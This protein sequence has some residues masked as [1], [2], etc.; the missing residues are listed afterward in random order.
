M[1]LYPQGFDVQQ[2]CLNG[3]MITDSYQNDPSSRKQFCP[4]CGA[5]KITSCPKCNSKIK[6]REYFLEKGNYGVDVTSIGAIV[7]TFCESCG[8]PF[9]WS[10]KI[11]EVETDSRNIPIIL[12]AIQDSLKRYKQ[13]YP[14]PE[15]TA[16]IMMRF[17]A[18]AQHREI[19]DVITTA[20]KN[21]KISGLRAD[22]LIFH[23]DLYYNILTYLHGCDFGVAV[24]EVIEDPEYNPNVAFEVGF[25]KALGKPVCLLKEKSLEKLPTD[26]IGKNY[27]EFDIND[28]EKSIQDE[29]NYWIISNGF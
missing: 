10:E 21:N 15:K 16:F 24:F 1:S 6:G 29:L 17:G 7:P 9:P 8:D 25:L 5:K 13:L 20:L 12:P 26:L 14:P 2:I 28:C 22:S 18:T 4:L 27:N 19:L 23:E 3:H 11:K